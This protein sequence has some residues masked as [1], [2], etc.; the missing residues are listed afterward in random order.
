MKGF[1][2]I[3]LTRSPLAGRPT[4]MAPVASGSFSGNGARCTEERGIGILAA[5]LCLP[6]PS[7]PRSKLELLKAG[8][9]FPCFR[10]LPPGFPRF[11]LFFHA[12]YL[13]FP[14]SPHFSMPMPKSFHPP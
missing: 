5:A 1:T 10:R 8:M 13:P 12:D 7:P 9:Q 6:I 14:V 2:C 3:C 11:S 4:E